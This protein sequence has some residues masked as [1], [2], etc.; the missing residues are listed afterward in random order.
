MNSKI[1]SSLNNRTLGWLTFLYRK[2]SVPDDWSEDGEPLEWWDKVSNPP[3]LNFARF[4]LSESSYALGLMSDVTPAWQEVYSSILK[5]LSE[6]HLTYWAAIDWLTQIGP[7]PNRK[8]YP[9][10]WVDLWIPEHLV[11]EY[12]TPGWVANG[13]EPWGLQKDPIG[14]DGNLFFKGWLNL[15]QSLHVYT[16]GEDTW[17]DQF[18]VAG[19]DRSRF[20]WTHHS[21]VEHL[22]SQWRNNPFGPHCENTKIW[23]YCLSAAGLGLKLYDSIFEKHTH[24]VYPEV[25]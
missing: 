17:G 22:T 14:A 7:D 21:L 23:P 13:I 8:N 3:V 5:G 9:K 10:E 25:G 19:V 24:Q 12:D 20:E 2:T 18:Q 11:G 15:I 4:D 1:S 6:R 16:T